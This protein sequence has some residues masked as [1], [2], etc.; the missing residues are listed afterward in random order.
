MKVKICCIQSID[1][2]RL[3]VKYGA[4]AI[5]L[6]SEMPS[7]PGVISEDMISEITSLVPPEIKT[8]LLSSKQTSKDIISQLIKCKTNTVQL[9]D[10]VHVAVYEQIRIQLPDISIVQV[11]HVTGEE[12]IREAIKVE[13]Y[14]DAV[15]LDS[16]N[17]KLKVK[18]LGGTGR[19]HNWE[20]SKQIAKQL[21][22]PVYLAGGLNAENV[23]EAFQFVNPY[24]VDL[25]SSVRTNNKLDENKL[26]KFFSVLC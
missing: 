12:S 11:I 14:V 22:I 15:L 17:Q 24:G 1:E 26:K 16:G 21:K 23:R 18:E 3:A 6:V 4:F 10:W 25:C 20:I 5:G 7:G 8:F 13:K 9:V 2:A 19:I